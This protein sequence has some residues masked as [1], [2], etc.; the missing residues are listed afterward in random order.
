M[1]YSNLGYD[2]ESRSWGVAAAGRWLAVGNGLPY[3]KAEVGAIA[4][5]ADANVS[6][7][8]QGIEML[9]KGMSAKEVLNALLSSDLGRDKRQVGII[10]KNG[11]VAGRFRLRLTIE[12]SLKVPD[13]FRCC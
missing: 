10:D 8:L 3:T 11:K 7:G 5:Q 13:L 1:T 6:Y 12:L 9:A 4:T 2:P